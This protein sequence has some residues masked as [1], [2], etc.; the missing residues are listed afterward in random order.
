EIPSVIQ[1]AMDI[2]NEQNFQLSDIK[3]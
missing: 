3:K 1:E 2:L